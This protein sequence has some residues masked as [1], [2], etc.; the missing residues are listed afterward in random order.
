MTN[1]QI[2]LSYKVPSSIINTPRQASV[3]CGVSVKFD[4]KYFNIA[5]DILMRRRFDSFVGFFSV[6]EGQNLIVRPIY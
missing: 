3:S 6:E 4:N 5:K 2:H 1:K